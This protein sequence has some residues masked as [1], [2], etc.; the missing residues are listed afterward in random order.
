QGQ[1]LWHPRSQVVPVRRWVPW[2]GGLA[3]P[4]APSVSGPPSRAEP[5]PPV[6]FTCTSGGFSPRDIAVTWLKNGAKLPAP[7]PRVLPAHESVSYSVSSTVGVSLTTGDTR[8]Q[9]TCQIE[10]S[11]LPAACGHCPSGARRTE[12]VC[13]VHL[14]CGGVLPKGRESHLAGE[15]T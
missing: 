12:Q 5:G 7:Q 2:G 15:R 4:S 1:G 8:S 9:L 11:T 10:H 14:P 13:D 6:T 3:R